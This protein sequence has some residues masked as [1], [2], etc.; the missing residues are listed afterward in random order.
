MRGEPSTSPENR[1]RLRAACHLV[2]HGIIRCA[3][4]SHA[5][6]SRTFVQR[7]RHFSRLRRSVI[8]CHFRSHLKRFLRRSTKDAPLSGSA[9]DAAIS[10]LE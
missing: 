3:T 7:N 2:L 1:F 10:R 8:V 9:G 5:L 4:P 6:A